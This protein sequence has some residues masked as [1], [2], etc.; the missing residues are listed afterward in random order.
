M[1]KK[2]ILFRADASAAIGTGHVMRCLALAEAWQDVGG[3]ATIAMAQST[4]AIEKRLR[5][6]NIQI[7]AFTTAPGDTSD[8]TQTASLARDLGTIWVVVDGYCF[9]ARYQSTLKEAGLKVL[10]IDDNGHSEHYS[11][12]I[13]LNQN[14]HASKKLYVSRADD[15][16]LLLGPRYA[17]LRREFHRWANWKRQIPDVG[18]R[19]LITLGGSDAANVTQRV[20]ECLSG[21]D[22]IPLEMVVV[23][24]GANPN[25][26]LLN[27]I[28]SRSEGN[29]RIET[30]VAN[31]D[32]LMAWCDVAIAAAGTT[33]WELCCLGV[34]AILLDVAENQTAVAQHLNRLGVAVHVDVHEGSFDDKLL[35]ELAS[36]MGSAELRSKMSNKGRAL[37]DGYG[38]SRVLSFFDPR[39]CLRSAEDRDCRLLWEWAN[40]PLTRAMSFSSE[41]IPWEAHV[42]W[43]QA[44]L[45]D[46]KAIVYI[47]A[48]MHGQP[49]GQLR[50]LTGEDR[51]T[52]S[53]SLVPEWRGRGLAL[54]IIN[55]GVEKF[56]RMSN[57][58]AIDAYIKPGNAA[59]LRLFPRAGFF[60]VGDTV[61]DGHSAMHFVLERP[62]FVA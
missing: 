8:A 10:F 30:D 26:E 53:I 54:E 61:I 42:S 7:D 57:V 12:D 1:D 39:I 15:T 58:R 11:A 24:G 28:A 44:R 5:A 59:S 23:V 62:E 56:F 37:V 46:P 34:P 22:T 20:V 33:S 45:A 31:M 47:A 27:K 40:D 55:V 9:G 41:P 25:A 38:A 52:I 35:S 49:V 19:I 48:D 32:E 13:V 21:F 50:F 16:R 43:F 29:V 51:A 2:T 3:A 17:L 36:L 18:R 4:P 14:A 6:R 60:R